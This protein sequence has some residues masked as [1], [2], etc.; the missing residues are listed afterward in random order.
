MPTDEKGDLD[1]IKLK[2]ARILKHNRVRRKVD[3]ITGKPS[4]ANNAISY[5][6]FLGRRKV[7]PITGNPS[8]AENAIAYSKFMNRRKVDPVTG[9][10]EDA[11]AYNKF[12]NRR[13]VDPVTGEPSEAED[14]IAYNKFM[15]RRK[16]DPATGE[17][18]SAPNSITYATY[19]CRKRA[20]RNV[21]LITREPSSA[22]TPSKDDLP[23]QSEQRFVNPSFRRTKKPCAKKIEKQKIQHK[24]TAG[25]IGLT[26]GAVTGAAVGIPV[27][28]QAAGTI[29]IPAL[30]SLVASMKLFV[31]LAISNPIGLGVTAGFV[32]GAIV[33]LL[34]YGLCGL[35]SQP[36]T[37]NNS[38]NMLDEENSE[39]L[40]LPMYNS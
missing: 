2:Q 21:V 18:S 16:V 9:E 39:G 22:I 11:I 3:P 20:R 32:A 1:V 33:G 36:A 30:A 14:A 4:T 29:S 24:A 15:N 10:A 13:K 17:P 40:E 12:M 19:R 23:I 27:G 28:L 8:K 7:D 34:I 5:N 38:M 35:C 6:I 26:A 25:K 31:P 37:P